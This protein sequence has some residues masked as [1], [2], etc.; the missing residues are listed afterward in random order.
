MV[1]QP[2]GSYTFS[3]KRQ[4]KTLTSAA[5]V[6]T[7]TGERTE[8]DSKNLYRRLL[9]IGVGEIHVGLLQYELCSFPASLFDNQLFMRSGDKAELIQHLVKLVPECIISS[10]PKGLQ[11]SLMEP[12][13]I[14]ELHT[15]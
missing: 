9:I 8:I 6:K 13:P 1:G 15:F 3:Q 5:H 14:V 10:L 11:M 12:K 2:V 4:V 7:S